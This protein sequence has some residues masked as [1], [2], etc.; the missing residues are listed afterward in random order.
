ML[1]EVDKHE[2]ALVWNFVYFWYTKK[3]VTVDKLII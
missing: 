3:S 2:L 1:E